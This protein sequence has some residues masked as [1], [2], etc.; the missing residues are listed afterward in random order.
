IDDLETL[1]TFEIGQGAGWSTAKILEDNGF[2]VVIGGTYKT[3]FP[4]LYA[5]RFQLL[6]R[7]VYE[8]FPEL[9]HYK[10]DMPELAIV[11]GIA[12]YTY[13]PMYFF[14]SKEQ[15]DLGDRLEYGLKK[16]HESGQIDTLFAQ[17]FGATLGYLN[18]DQR[19]VFCV[20]NTNIDGSFYEND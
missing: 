17:Y 2:K 6:M 12:I 3:L 1:K 7:G 5:N 20:A 9:D 14:V 10:P 15:P 18:L 13:L 19:T 11:D 4:M 8:I 16:A